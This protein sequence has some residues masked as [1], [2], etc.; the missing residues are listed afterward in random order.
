MA[1]SGLALDQVGERNRAGAQ[2]SR[3]A[4]RDWATGFLLILPAAVILGVFHLFGIAY[5]V[6]VSTFKWA[7]NPEA[8]LGTGNYASLAHD[9][10]FGLALL[11]TVFF[12]VGTVPFEMA[13]GVVLA[14]LLFREIAAR[15][16]YRVIYFLPYVTSAVA[17]GVIFRWIFNG[18]G[19]ANSI[20]ELLGLPKQKWLLESTGVFQLIAGHFGL[21][22]PDWAGGP[23]QALVAIMAATIWSATGFQVVLFLAGLSAIPTEVYEAARIDGATE[24]QITRRITLPLLRPTIVFVA[25]ISTIFAFRSFSQVYQMSQPNAGGPINSTQLATIFIFNQF[26]RYSHVGYAAAAS[27]IVFVIILAMTLTN[28]RRLA[29]S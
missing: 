23:S 28:R 29:P 13:I 5:L 24:W 26:Y 20:L 1:A 8:F 27:L 25:T 22:I 17:V 15:G 11:Q 14:V 18:N 4:R 2:R 6:Y 19:L 10:D 21:Q 7:I 9:A 12:V 3:L 16:F